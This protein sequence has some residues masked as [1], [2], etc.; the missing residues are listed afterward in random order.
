[1]VVKKAWIPN[2]GTYSVGTTENAIDPTIGDVFY[3][4]AAPREETK[5]KV[6]SEK[7]A[8]VSSPDKLLKDN[9]DLEQFLNIASLANLAQLHIHEGE[10]KARGDPT[11]IAIQ[12]FASRFNWNRSR[13]TGDNDP[14]WAQKAEYPFDSSIKKMSVIFESAEHTMVFTKGA[15][16]RVLESCSIIRYANGNVKLTEQ[17]RGQILDNVEA[18]A[19]QGLRV[20]AFASN[21]LINKIDDLKVPKRAVIESD[22]VFRG[23]VGLYDPPRPE[24]AG[25]VTAC[26]T[27]GI[28]VHMLT[29][30]HPSTAKAIA[31]Q[32][33]ILPTNIEAIAQDKIRSMVMTAGQFDKLSNDEVDA[34]PL[35]PLVI[36]RC[37]PATKVRMIE[38][39]HRRGRF[40]AM[41]GDGV[42]DSPSLKYADVGIAMGLAGSDVAKDASDIILT[43]DNFASIINAVEEGRRMFD[44]IQKFILHLLAENVAQALTLLI[45]L[46]FK[47]K[48]NLSVFPLA[49]VEILWVIMI[50]SG[51]RVSIHPHNL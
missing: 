7:D 2:K 1:M 25:A 50:T 21:E 12:V 42:N 18:L 13:W 38:S 11:D 51:E 16:E 39:L 29:G 40:V 32:V 8:L 35:L 47:D 20:L 30:D 23:L 33:G 22:L 24:T 37:S 27:S 4:K 41:T 17:I 43:N 44:N 31:L 14:I 19:S 9:N 46:V 28:A 5:E 3:C 34:L 26:H 6:S 45:G 48:S 36:A 49:P 10:W 15:V